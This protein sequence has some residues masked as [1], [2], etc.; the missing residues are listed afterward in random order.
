MQNLKLL[1][2]SKILLNSIFLKKITYNY[3]KK[4]LHIFFYSINQTNK[5]LSLI[6]LLI[7]R[8]KYSILFIYSNQ[9]QKSRFV[10]AID[11]QI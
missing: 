9:I 2:Q 11:F 1:Y 6:C 10:K 5:V 3:I 4:Y 8:I 7:F